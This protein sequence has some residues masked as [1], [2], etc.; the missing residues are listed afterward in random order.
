MASEEDR[1]KIERDRLLAQL[2]GKLWYCIER[3]VNEET[4]FD[5]VCSAKFINALVELCYIQL[6]EMGKDLEMFSRHANRDVINND[7]LKLL[8]RKV[9][10]LQQ[11][12][13][14]DDSS[15]D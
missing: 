8:L 3:Q 7:D 10:Q 9:P 11:L 2:K 15:T 13:F 12:I 4:P 14:N 5:T 6:V 1:S